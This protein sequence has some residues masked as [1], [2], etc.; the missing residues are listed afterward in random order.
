M[1]ARAHLSMTQLRPSQA[2]NSILCLMLVLLFAGSFEL[3]PAVEALSCSGN[4]TT[5]QVGIMNPLC[6]S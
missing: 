1:N 2:L 5:Q 6:E 3:S 4:S